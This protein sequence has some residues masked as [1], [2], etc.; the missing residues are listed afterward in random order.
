MYKKDKSIE[1]FEEDPYKQS[2]DRISNLAEKASECTKANEKQYF[3]YQIMVE[4][5]KVFE[6][7]KNE[8]ME[9]IPEGTEP[10]K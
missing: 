3:I 7:P 10:K 5:C 1:E 4:Y 6:I 8:M 2:L 9:G